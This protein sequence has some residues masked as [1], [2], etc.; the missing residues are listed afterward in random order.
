MNE[1]RVLAKLADEARQN[2]RTCGSH[3]ARQPLSMLLTNNDALR[4]PGK[5]GYCWK[6]LIVRDNITLAIPTGLVNL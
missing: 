5:S 1:I 3:P 4:V 2:P 6:D